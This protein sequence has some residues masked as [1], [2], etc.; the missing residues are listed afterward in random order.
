MAMRK[1]YDVASRG[2]VDTY[3]GDFSE[4]NL[5]KLQ[6]A[7]WGNPTEQ[8]KVLFELIDFKNENEYIMWVREWH[9]V[10]TRMMNEQKF[11]KAALRKGGW[12]RTKKY[13]ISHNDMLGTVSRSATLHGMYKLR[14]MGK[15]LL[16]QF[17]VVDAYI[18]KVS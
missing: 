6:R 9:I 4:D 10:H 18:K 2:Y 3:Y 13:R 17:Q 5:K 15:N 12:A 1:T 11:Y 8:S 7:M 16:K 14:Q